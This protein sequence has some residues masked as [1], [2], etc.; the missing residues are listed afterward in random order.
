LPFPPLPTIGP[1]RWTND[2]N[3]MRRLGRDQ[4]VGIPIAAVEHVGP[5][6]EIPIGQVLLNGGAHNAIWRGR[7]HRH[8]PCDEIWVV[9]ITGLGEMH[10]IT[11]PM[12]LAWTAVVGLQVEGDGIRTAAGGDS[13]PVR[14]RSASRPCTVQ[15]S[16]G[17]RQ[18]CRR[19]ARPGSSLRPGDVSAVCAHARS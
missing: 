17:G 10:L 12:G 16:S 4:E 8:D 15:R 6:Q 3:L 18:I 19:A 1:K 13:S 9:G 2:I 7:W 14:P 5:G 11:H